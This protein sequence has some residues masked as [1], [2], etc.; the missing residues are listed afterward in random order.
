MCDL[1]VSI[2][3][4]VLNIF[5]YKVYTFHKTNMLTIPDLIWGQCTCQELHSFFNKYLLSVLYV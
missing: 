4:N 5:N 2:I 1:L 3:Y